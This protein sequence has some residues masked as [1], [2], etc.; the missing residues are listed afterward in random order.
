ML[1]ANVVWKY[2]SGCR[3]RFPFDV[4]GFRP[5]TVMSRNHFLRQSFPHNLLRPIALSHSPHTAYSNDALRT[6]SSSNSPCRIALSKNLLRATACSR[7]SL[8]GFIFVGLLWGATALFSTA[9]AATVRTMD[10]VVDYKT[11]HFA[12]RPRMALAINDQIPAPTLHF[13]EGDDVVLRVHNHLKEG[14]AIHWHGL[15]VPWRM[16]G[17]EHLSQAPIPPGGT[18]E[19]RFKLKQSGTYWYHA[20]ADLQE[21]EGIYGAFKIDPLKPPA[22]RYQKD[23]A[24]VLSDWSNTR[25]REVYA[26]LKKSGDF[27]APNLP[28]QPSLSR[29]LRDYQAA[30]AKV[31]TKLRA[32]YLMMQHMRMSIYDLS[33]IAYDAYLLNGHTQTHPWSARVA[34]G[35]TVRLR[36]VGAAASSFFH[37]KIPGH[38]MQVVHVQ[39][40][41]VKPYWTEDFSIAP[42]ETWDVL[43]PIREKKAYVIYGETADKKGT[44][45][46]VLYT[47]DEQQPD[48]KSII[49]FPT[50][51]PVMMGEAGH[52]HHHH[53]DHHE[54][55]SMGMPTHDHAAMMMTHHAQHSTDAAAMPTVSTKTKYQGLRSHV[56]TNDP[57]RPVEIIQMRL[58]GFMDRYQWFINDIP[59]HQAPPIRIQHGKRYRIIFTNETMMHHPMHI[60]GHF[61]ILRNGYGAFDPFLHTIE[62]APGATVVADF[63]ADTDGKWFFHCHHLYHM[64]AGMARIFEYVEATPAAST[65]GKRGAYAEHDHHAMLH[66]KP[67]P[68]IAEASSS[69]AHPAIHPPGVYLANSLDFGVDPFH[70]IQK[71]S[72]E[73]LFGSDEH[74]LQ[75]FINDAE[76][77]EGRIENADLDIFYWHPV[78]EFWSVKGG[79]NYFYRPSSSPYWQPGI[80][81]EGLFPYFIEMDARA[82]YHD[83]S[84]KMDVELSRDTQ[85]TDNFLV[86]LAARGIAATKTVRK[87]E[88]GSGLNELR[89]VVRPYYRVMPGLALYVEYEHEQA[90]GTL[91]KL[92]QEDEN[93]PVK[94]DIFSLGFSWLF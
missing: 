18:F 22:Y 83:G 60:H 57:N 14:T 45:Y 85:I 16:D 5:R 44:V 13:K 87:D 58:T 59:E 65:A 28:L 74:K 34:M 71:L 1:K 39:G 76:M 4:N 23:F 36:F 49:P 51:A 81:L 82:Y 50:P 38:K 88:I 86:K 42:G 3:L 78:S 19:Y 90:Y 54:H 61:F 8:H 32:D 6:A 27:Y 66:P 15:L 30:D 48:L 37:I 25:A 35:D 63:D 7:H 26:N 69:D 24:V 40:H 94:Q 21:Q 79:V 29:F 89:F 93:F 77:E 9:Q 70:N 17:V 2:F 62:V 73:S 91:K 56:K 47:G 11:V 72:F 10:L 20:H 41:D 52:A 53:A 84:A 46:G 43:V 55:H 64:R 80:G 68:S 67:A 12:G 31:R 92:F 75:L 33:D